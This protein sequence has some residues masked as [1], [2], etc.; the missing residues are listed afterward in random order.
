VP[1]RSLRCGGRLAQVSFSFSTF[2]L[3]MLLLVRA[4]SQGVLFE[5]DECTPLHTQPLLPPDL[6]IQ[7]SAS[8]LLSMFDAHVHTVRKFQC[9]CLI[10]FVQH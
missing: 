9:Q 7:C 3:Q 4:L 1:T 5:M 8:F 10:P 6:S 2:R